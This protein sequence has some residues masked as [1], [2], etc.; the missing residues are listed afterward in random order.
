MPG[1][2]PGSTA[3]AAFGALPPGPDRV[4]DYVFDLIRTAIID[5]SLPPGS[6]VVESDLA[7]RL[8][9]S[10]TPV[11]ESM[12]RLKELG[13][14]ETVG[15]R[16][17]VVTPSPQRIREAYEFRV[18]LEPQCAQLA[19][20]RASPEQ[21]ADL[22]SGAERG[23]VVA[24]TRGTLG[25]YDAGYEFHRRVAAAS[26]N[27]LLGGA[28]RRSHLY[29]LTLTRRDTHGPIDQ[30]GHADDHLAIA[31]AIGEGDGGRAFD[32]MERHLQ[33]L[34]VSALERIGDE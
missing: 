12:I 24:D 9:V 18:C 19:A 11:R 6:A 10:K 28:V 8:N 30:P 3:P 2:D 21:A 16:L 26:G 17:R 5:K 33:S 31:Q 34:L 13:L 14:L 4:T 32:L 23:V 1:P 20:E 22:L 15:R 27:S 7:T 29:T 25:F